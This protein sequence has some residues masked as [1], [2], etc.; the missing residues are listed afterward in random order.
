MATP[1]LV[2]VVSKSVVIPLLNVRSRGGRRKCFFNYPIQV[3]SVLVLY[4]N[5]V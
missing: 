5:T 4:N 3:Q 2:V 1:S